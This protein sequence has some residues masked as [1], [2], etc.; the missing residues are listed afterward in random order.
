MHR[1]KDNVRREDKVHKSRDGVEIAVELVHANE[2]SVVVECS[3]S[4]IESTKREDIMEV[5]YNKV[6]IMHKGIDNGTSKDK[7]SKTA[8]R[9]GKDKAENV[10]DRSNH[11]ETAGPDGSSSV[12][13]FDGSRD[14]DN[15]SSRSKVGSGIDVET[16]DKHMVT[17]DNTAKDTNNKESQ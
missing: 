2:S 12:K 3:E 5:G 9:E 17:S 4:G 14:S 13:D 10:I 7:A 15:R 16:D 6:G 1:H 8:E 11:K